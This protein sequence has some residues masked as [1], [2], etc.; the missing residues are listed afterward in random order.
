[1]S[2]FCHIGELLMKTCVLILLLALIT[3]CNNNSDVS[4]EVKTKDSIQQ[5]LRTIRDSIKKY[6]AEVRL[7]YNLAVVLQDAG[8]YNEALKALD[9]MNIQ[10]PDSTDPYIYPNYLFKRAELLELTGDTVAAI[11][12]LEQIVTQGDL[13]Q[14]A[15]NLTNL[16]AETGD[17]K[18]LEFANR[19]I[20]ENPEIP[21]PEPYYF[22]GIYYSNTGQLQK[23]IT[24]FDS[25][26]KKDYTFL[27]AHLEKGI[28][29]HK[30]GKNEEAIKTFDLALKV[31]GSFA[32]AYFWKA[33]A[34]EAM[35]LKEDAKLN[36]QRAFG[37]D[38]TLT[39]A[40]DSADNL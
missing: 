19:M 25:S 23:A 28:V 13:T 29:Y 7:K 3:G 38:R 36:Y 15:L 20:R 24:E 6:P 40:Q 17:P 4:S 1:M 26:I 31:S 33:K 22:K 5:L 35:G 21:A 11:R 37:L 9:S 2:D 30:Q 16:Y 32:D 12:S 10:G 18:A 8:Q 14:A 34:Q 27:L 39:A